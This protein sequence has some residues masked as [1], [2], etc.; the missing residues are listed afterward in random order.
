MN[1]IEAIF[2][3]SLPLQFRGFE[4]VRRLIGVSVGSA[5][6]SFFES[7]RDSA[8]H[9]KCHGKNRSADEGCDHTKQ[10]ER[11]QRDTD[12]K[13]EQNCGFSIH[14]KYLSVFEL[15]TKI[16]VERQINPISFTHTL[17]GVPAFCPATVP[18]IEGQMQRPR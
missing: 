9:N 4:F 10:E 15:T 1:A 6:V 17:E 5:L 16:H 7:F 8:Q 2:Y 11:G 13:E 12:S 14:D 3:R 18:A